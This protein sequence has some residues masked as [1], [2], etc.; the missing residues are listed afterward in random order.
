MAIDFDRIVER[1]GTNCYK[2][3][4]M[5]DP[6]VLPMWVADMDFEVAPEIKAALQRRLDHGVFGYAMVPEDYYEAVIDWFVRRHDWRIARESMIVTQGVVPA[7]SAILQAITQPGER[8][9]VMTPIYNCFFSSIRNSGCEAVEVPLRC[10]P[11]GYQIDWDALE[12]ALAAERTR[13]LLFCSPHNPAG[14]VW[15]RTELQRVVKLCKQHGVRIISDE[16]HCE[17]VYGLNL[18]FPT[19]LFDDSVVTCVSPSK[20]F[21]IAGLQNAIIVCNDAATRE[22]IDRRININEVCD[23]NLFGI[24]A[25]KAAYRHGEQWIGELCDYVMGN[26]E[27]VRDTIHAALPQLHVMPLEGTYLAWIDCRALGRTSDELVQLLVERGKLC[28]SSGSI[29]G[30]A[31]EGFVRMNLATSRKRVEEGTRRFIATL[32]PLA[33]GQN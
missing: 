15:N 16:I 19:A 1:R 32:S 5:Q 18:H 22:R 6:D 24:E 21:N 7:I 11:R 20:A 14:R 3:D 27:Y 31:G 13:V 33:E 10:E 4:S 29:Y 12:T 26:Y 17:F 9:V 25:V 8:V 30:H 23:V 2:W 28:L